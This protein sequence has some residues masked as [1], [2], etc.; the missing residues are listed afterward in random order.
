[1]RLLRRENL[2]TV[3]I[4]INEFIVSSDILTKEDIPIEFLKYLRSNNFKIEDGALMNEIFD[5]I[6]DKIR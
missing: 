2:T 1:M 3:L 5:M 6:E 4:L